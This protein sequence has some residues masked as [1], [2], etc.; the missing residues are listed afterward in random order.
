VLESNEIF[1]RQSFR[2]T[3]R[4]SHVAKAHF[5]KE[6]FQIDKRILGKTISLIIIATSS[7][8]HRF[9]PQV[10]RSRSSEQSEGEEHSFSLSFSRRG[11]REQAIFQLWT[12]A[13]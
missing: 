7:R 2:W 10:R 11:A 3:N 12:S 13:T 6:D 1:D 4:K 5:I 8:L 9:E